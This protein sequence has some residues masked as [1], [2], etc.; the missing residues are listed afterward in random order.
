MVKP[1]QKRAESSEPNPVKCL[2]GNAEGAG[3]ISEILKELRLFRTE[4]AGN[5]AELKQDIADLK[6]NFE[7]LETR[8]ED[9]EE[10]IAHNEDRVMELTKVIFHL[11]RKQKH[12][13]DKCEDLES[14]S[15][16]KN[17]RIYSVPEKMEGNNI[18]EF[19]EKLFSEKLNI[20]EEIH[21]ERAHR[22][23]AGVSSGRKDYTRSI[24]VRFRSYREKQKVLHAAWA[25]KEIRVNDQRI[26]FD[27]DFTSDVFKERAM[28]RS[29]RKQLQERKVKSRILFPAKL[30]LFL[31][32][33]KTK[34]FNCPRDAAE[35]LQEFGVTMETPKK[36]P[37]WETALRTA[38]WH[39]PRS[40]SK[41]APAG[42]ISTI[43][44]TLR[45]SLDQYENET[46]KDK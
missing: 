6:Q 4:T 36:E 34:T 31:Q 5:F 7:K 42:E 45:D 10:R 11:M 35:G 38:G 19:I 37:D 33:G 22:T 13:E 14:R 27:E 18:V 43:V 28:Y 44:E 8:V 41:H 40:K 1:S 39:S 9:A 29:A 24:I 32:D 17:L 25:Q 2:V 20:R 16:R 15:R 46:V 12:L 26:Y 30:K 3:E 21:I 23:A